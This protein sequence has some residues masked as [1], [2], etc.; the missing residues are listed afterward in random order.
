MGDIDLTQQADF[1]DHSDRHENGSD[2]ELNVDGLSGVLA[3]EQ[4]PQS[5]A[6]E[7][8]TEN[9]I[10]D[11]EIGSPN[12]VAGLTSDGV[13]PNGQVPS[14]AVTD[15][16]TVETEDDLTTLTDA[17][18]G[19]VGIVTAADPED[20]NTFILTGED[21]TVQEDWV[22]VQ[23][24][25]SP[26]QSV[27][28]Q[29]GDVVLDS[30]DVEAPS[31]NEFDSHAGRHEDDGTDELNVDG[32]SGVLADQ[33]D[34]Q[35]HANERHTENFIPDTEIGAA[36][37]VA[38]LDGSAQVPDSQSQ[39]ASVNGQKGDVDL[40]NDD[41]GAPS[42][43]QFEDHDHSGGE[44]EPSEINPESVEADNVV[45]NDQLDAPQVDTRSDIPDGQ[46]GFYYVVDEDTI[47][48]RVS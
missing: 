8:H 18:L 30:D 44:G 17:E 36:D 5:H 31:Q 12:G 11:T 25:Q 40:D 6:N 32:L 24:P 22:E 20:N 46:T 16:S 27:N 2:D 34:P 41:V 47:T 1:E 33:Q 23:S 37:G 35:S 9:F 10:P 43:G 26:V 21:P 13:L 4:E 3:D 42:D 29:T 28:D 7:R 38:S 19:D 15:V 45:G 39:V 48:F 14:I